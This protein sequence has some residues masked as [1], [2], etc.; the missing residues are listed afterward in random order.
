[1]HR[2]ALLDKG[3]HDFEEV[4]FLPDV[5]I[6]WMVG[7][8]GQVREGRCDEDCTVLV[9]EIV[10][11]HLQETIPELALIAGLDGKDVHDR[12]AFAGLDAAGEQELDLRLPRLIGRLDG[13][14]EEAVAV[15]LR[16][17]DAWRWMVG[18]RHSNDGGHRDGE[19]HTS[20]LRFPRHIHA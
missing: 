5:R 9:V 6:G 10:P 3:H 2:I 14:H 13:M 1:M 7:V 16:L 15:L 18:A 4:G 11:L 8:P 12:V 19:D 17:G 20:R